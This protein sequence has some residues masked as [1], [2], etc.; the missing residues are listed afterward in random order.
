MKNVIY[1][2]IF[3]F[4]TGCLETPTGNLPNIKQSE[5]DME[6]E[7]QKRISFK[8]Y[9]DQMSQAKEI[10]YKIN[11]SNSDICNK[12]DY[13]SGIT[14]ANENNFGLKNLRFYPSNLNLGPQVSIIHIA[15]NSPAY[16]AG[17][18]VGDIILEFGDYELPKGKNALEKISKHFSNI[19]KQET[20]NIKIDRKGEILDFNFSR[21]KICDYPI[22]LTRD[23]IVN[24]FADGKS[25]IMTQGM[26]DYARDDNEVAIVIAH[27]LAH[28][29]RGH[30]DAKKKNMLVMGSIGFILDLMTIYYSGGTA[31]G[32]AENT[33]LWTKIG[34]E[35]YSVEFEKDADYGGVYYAYRAGY[36][37][38][39][40]QK[41]W[42]RIGADNPN[43]IAI[44]STHPATAE[45][46]LQIEKTVEEINRKQR[47]G[48]A[49]VPN[50]KKVKEKNEKKQKKKKKKF[51]LKKLIKK[52]E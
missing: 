19:E 24:A 27:E 22:I 40:V 32:S 13:N 1:F 46:Y 52:K 43:R 9:I 2:F 38:S 12:V 26:M 20:T 21:T 33:E 49:L 18:N 7:R 34:S 39:N 23:K 36:D 45:R 3:L 31:G 4:L 11:S 51:N 14:Y 37:V 5:I 6:A 17:L 50:E 28:N 47:D 16:K 15:E 41:F 25:I 29:D 30:L 10:G 42:E 48:L 8:K 44:S 35:A